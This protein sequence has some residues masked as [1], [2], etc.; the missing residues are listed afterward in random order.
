METPYTY[1]LIRTDL[2]APRQLVQASHAA[3]LA[4]ERFG[5]HSHLIAMKI[6]NEAE[7]LRA[8]AHL[9]MHGINYAMFHEPDYDTGYTAICTEPLRGDQRKPLRRYSL[10]T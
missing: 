6:S 9:D 1:L 10:L 2:S 8:A 7:L 5:D 3:H 4:G